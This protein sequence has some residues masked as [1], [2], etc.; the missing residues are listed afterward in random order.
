MSYPSTLSTKIQ[1]I[2]NYTQNTVKIFPSNSL[3]TIVVTNGNNITID[4]PP[5]S[6]VDLSSLTINATFSTDPF[7]FSPGVLAPAAG[8][9]G[10]QIQ[11]FYL[12]RDANILIDR[13]TITIG[14]NTVVDMQH[15]NLIQQMFA[16][17]QY[18]AESKTKRLLQNMDAITKYSDAGA[19][20]GL[21]LVTAV[22]GGINVNQNLATDKR[23][24]TLANFISFL[25]GEPR[26]IDT[27][28][29]G[30]I[31]II[32]QLA[33]AVNVLY[34]ADPYNVV[35]GGAPFVLGAAQ[36]PSYTLD[37]IYATILKAN[38]DDGIFY[39]SISQALK[40]GI[41]LTMK[42]KSYADMLGNTS[43]NMSQTLR[44]ETSGESV[45]LILFT[46]YNNAFRTTTGL[47]GGAANTTAF[48]S[49][50]P[51][52][53]SITNLGATGVTVNGAAANAAYAGVAA[54][55]HG[56]DGT[57]TWYAQRGISNSFTSQFFNRIGT[58]INT[59]QFTVNG[60][61]IPQFYMSQA[62]I[63]QQLLRDTG[64][65]STDNGIYPGINSYQSWRDNYWLASCRLDH[66]CPEKFI[67]GFNTSG[68]P[69][70][71]Q[72]TTTSSLPGSA[73]GNVLYVPH[74]VVEST[75]IVEIFAGRNVNV[76]K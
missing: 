55:A 4:L 74:I 30:Q 27:R 52:I 59:L 73:P 48:T 25:G 71:I 28:I 46:F 18:S 53:P 44:F 35:G 54:P 8:T 19:V 51:A 24:I 31:R 22:A 61:N 2:V 66:L 13:M 49:L 68:V 37:G 72:I 75:R 40:S 20:N 56:A 23:P 58:Y 70:V 39:S 76:L 63:Y 9:N 26:Y 60:E 50:T 32:L 38:I 17:Y 10:A 3:S 34:Q 1:K 64:S 12:C 16:D 7:A 45:D 15:Y 11:P 5:N 43:T 14:G 21:G 42:Y 47:I 57:D 33:P 6:L 36:N 41:P 29:T 65:N 62:D 69:L 67:S